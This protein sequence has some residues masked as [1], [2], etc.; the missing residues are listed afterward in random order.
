MEFVAPKN[1]VNFTAKNSMA[2]LEFANLL[3]RT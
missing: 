2:E 1:A 3:K